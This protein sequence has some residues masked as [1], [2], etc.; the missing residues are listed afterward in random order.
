MVAS[1][2]VIS[3]CG[4]GAQ[5]SA[6]QHRH[7]AAGTPWGRDPPQGEG[8]PRTGTPHPPPV[9]LLLTSKLWD[10]PDR[11]PGSFS[12]LPQTHRAAQDAQRAPWEP[13]VARPQI[14]GTGPHLHILPQVLLLL[15]HAAG[16]QWRLRH[17]HGLLWGE[18]GGISQEPGLPLPCPRPHSRPHPVAPT[19]SHP[20]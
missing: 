1:A 5:R 4:E 11:P 17:L 14:S 15:Q 10:G 16:V 19:A 20:P 9:V 7:G 6:R 12:S 3:S 8:P 18:R 13:S 2:L